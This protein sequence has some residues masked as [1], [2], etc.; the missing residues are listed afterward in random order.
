MSEVV[1]PSPDV[2]SNFHYAKDLWYGI[3]HDIYIE[4]SPCT[5]VIGGQ[6]VIV[7]SESRLGFKDYHENIQQVTNLYQTLAEASKVNSLLFCE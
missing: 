1:N 7:Q 3:Q 2:T 6:R 5:D 4:V